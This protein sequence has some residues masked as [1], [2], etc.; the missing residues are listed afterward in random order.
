MVPE[1]MEGPGPCCVVAAVGHDK[2]GPGTAL[3]GP[4]VVGSFH[5]SGLGCVVWAEDLSE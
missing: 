2:T 1:N 5:P 4:C 3:A